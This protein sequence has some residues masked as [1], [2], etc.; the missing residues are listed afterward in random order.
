MVGLHEMRSTPLIAKQA[1]SMDTYNTVES[2]SDSEVAY[3]KVG[4]ISLLVMVD[5]SCCQ[6]LPWMPV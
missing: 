5:I 3:S 6:R 1:P 4:D 2:D